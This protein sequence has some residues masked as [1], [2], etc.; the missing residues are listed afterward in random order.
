MGSTL[1]VQS[2]ILFE[3]AMCSSMCQHTLPMCIGEV[4][5]LLGIGP[6]LLCHLPVS[7]LT[8]EG[9]S[10]GDQPPG[11]CPLGEQVGHPPSHINKGRGPV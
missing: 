3:M 9:A 8:L 5:V 10:G 6:E 11:Y 2:M 7:A 4:L 1:Q